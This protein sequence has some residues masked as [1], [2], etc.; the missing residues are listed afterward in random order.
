MKNIDLR[1]FPLCSQIAGS[2][3]RTL[4]L[5]ILLGFT[6]NHYLQGQ[7]CLTPD[8]ND[9]AT[10]LTITLSSTASTSGDINELKDNINPNNGFFFN[11]QNATGVTYV[12]MEFPSPTVLKGIDLAVGTHLFNNNAFTEIQASN[13]NTNWTTLVVKGHPGGTNACAYGPCTIAETWSFTDNEDAYIYYRIQG[14]GGTSRSTPFVNELYF[15]TG[16]T[17]STGL[18][19]IS[20]NPGAD[21]FVTADD[22]ISFQLNPTGGSGTYNVSVAGTTVMPTSGSFGTPTT[23]TLPAGT[24][25]GGDLSLTVTG[26]TAGCE[27]SE[28]LLDPGTCLPGSCDVPNWNEVANKSTLTVSATAMTDGDINVLLDGND[29]NESFFYPDE[30]IANLEVLRVE[31]P[32]PTILRGIEYVIGN[33]YMYNTNATTVVQASNDGSTWVDMVPNATNTSPSLVITNNTYVKNRGLG[34]NHPGVI[35]NAPNTERYFWD[36][37]TA[38]TYYRIFGVSGNTNQNPWINE[39]FFDFEVFDPQ[40]TS[41]GCNDNG[42]FEDYTDDLLTFDLNPTLGTPGQMYLV[43]VS[44][45]FTINPS[46]GTYGQ[47]TSF[48]VS[49][50]SSGA[51]DLTVT[52]TDTNKPC[53]VDFVIPNTENGC[54]PGPCGEPDWNDPAQKAMII[55]TFNLPENNSHTGSIGAITDSDFA[56]AI[57]TFNNFFSEQEVFVFQFPQETVLQGIELSF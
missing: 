28:T 36:N 6:G 18:T 42:T 16:Q 47:M 7:A 17:E 23:F 22:F 2:L 26:F 33:S 11:F 27:L 41:H 55:G 12:L 46:M 32:D 8:Y 31:F 1:N 49:S 30:P 21:I 48:T 43:E 53:T 45:G 15:L 5:L 35:S 19:Q 29:E 44:G 4:A 57:G 14:A 56:T 37:T 13:D 52:L 34:N 54:I 10:K 51:G 24:A 25:G 38:Y 3:T 20:C 9:P 40:I 50:G 39:L